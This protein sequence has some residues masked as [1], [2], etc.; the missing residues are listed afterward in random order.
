MQ[1]N[2][3]FPSLHCFSAML[4]PTQAISA[5]AWAPL[6]GSKTINHLY[7]G[8][9]PPTPVGCGTELNHNTI[10]PATKASLCQQMQY[11][12]INWNT[13]SLTPFSGKQ[14]YHNL[15]FLISFSHLTIRSAWPA[16][17]IQSRYLVCEQYL[18][19]VLQVQMQHCNKYEN[20]QDLSLPSHC[21]Y[22][23]KKLENK[24]H[25]KAI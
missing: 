13:P 11:F 22:E 23:R 1:R 9:V 14:D 4:Y 21:C 2:F 25:V 18:T 24:I 7:T 19:D 10:Q 15:A 6:P 20:N 17:T 8:S 3:S 5:K 16:E 12:A